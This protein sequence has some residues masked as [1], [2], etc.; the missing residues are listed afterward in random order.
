MLALLFSKAHS[1][2]NYDYAPIQ[3]SYFIYRHEWFVLIEFKIRFNVKF[4]CS[5]TPPI[6]ND[7]RPTLIYLKTFVFR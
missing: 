4:K 3:S 7:Y 1:A 6:Y 2:R 5:S